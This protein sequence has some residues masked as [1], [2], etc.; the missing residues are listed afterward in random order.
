MRLQLPS[1][2]ELH[3]F[4]AAART[5]SFSAAAEILFV[6]QGGVSRSVQR[7]E[8]RLGAPLFSRHGRGVSLTPLGQ[9][10]FDQ[11]EPAFQTLTNAMAGASAQASS[12]DVL[13]LRTVST[14]SM[15]WLVPRLPQFHERVPGVRVVM[16]P[17]ILDDDFLD[18]D[19]DCW[20]YWRKSA[21]GAW[22]RHLRA[23][24]IIG[25]DTVPICHPSLAASIST[26]TDLL[27]HP[28]LYHV[29]V[30]D[31]WPLW[32]D[33]Y[34]VAPPRRLDSEFNIM[35]GLIDAVANKLGVSLSPRCL[36]QMDLQAGRIA[37]PPDMS[38]SNGRGYYFCSPR[39][40]DGDPVIEA[41]RNWLLECSAQDFEAERMR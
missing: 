29:E 24:Y 9:R 2:P 32:C 28:V 20:L 5:G 36:I 33:T 6:T 17:N 15:R 40:R 27:R 16:Q 11:L 37:V 3:A 22:P 38:F 23:S 35:A 7:L 31:F 30:P 14:L 12:R 39:A 41:F 1:M 4:I 19:V 13:R 10:L 34:G 25:R 26:P 18:G 8:T 21:S